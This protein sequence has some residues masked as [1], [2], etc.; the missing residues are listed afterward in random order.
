M[1]KVAE[2][3]ESLEYGPARESADLADAWLDRHH[4][5]FGHFIGGSW[6]DEPG[7]DRFDAWAHGFDAGVSCPFYA[8]IRETVAS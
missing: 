8:P 3:F 1:S 4:R 6:S 5:S 7:G 2:V